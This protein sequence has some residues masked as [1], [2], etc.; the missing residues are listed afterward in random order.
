MTNALVV[1]TNPRL[2]ALL[3]QVEG[4]LLSAAQ[5]ELDNN[6]DKAHMTVSEQNAVV[7]LR[8]LQL[9]K[10]LDLARMVT[11]ASLWSRNLV[12]NTVSNHPEGFTSTAQMAE[13]IGMSESALSREKDVV[14]IVFPWMRD[15]FISR[16]VVQYTE[17]Y[18]VE[19]EI[20]VSVEEY[21]EDEENAQ[22]MMTSLAPIADQ[23]VAAWWENTSMGRVQ[24]V[25]PILK[26]LI[27]GNQSASDRVN[28]QAEQLV[29]NTVA[30]MRAGGDEGEDIRERATVMTAEYL[31][32]DLATQ[33]VNEIRR[34]IRQQTGDRVVADG[35]IIRRGD[36]A[37]I[38]M[39]ADDESIRQVIENALVH[40]GRADL[41]TINLPEDDNRRM[42][43]ELARVPEVQRLMRLL[44]EE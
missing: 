12:T 8:A 23:Y 7:N 17:R 11:G 19:N 33:P 38:I 43:L 2:N 6:P 9:V 14:T 29:D 3:N 25:L 21:L 4:K 34:T 32:E 39:E 18:L 1:S 30:T 13:F 24:E 15:D 26:V 31:L 37:F 41:R 35:T 20:D 42:Q 44:R 36:T 10:T 28:T 27:T 5:L 16:T 22:A 40:T